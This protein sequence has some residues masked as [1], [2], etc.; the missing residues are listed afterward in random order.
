MNPWDTLSHNASPGG[1]QARY[2]NNLKL[3]EKAKCQ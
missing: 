1:D 3:K 2:C